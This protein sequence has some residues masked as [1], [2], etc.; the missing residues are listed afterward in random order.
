MPQGTELTAVDVAANLKDRVDEMLGTI[1]KDRDAHLSN[2][3]YLNGIHTLPKIPTFATDEII[4]LRRRAGRAKPDPAGYDVT[5]TRL[6]EPSIQS[7]RFAGSS[8]FP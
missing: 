7:V 1:A 4:E 6:V 2:Q 3:A 8:A 5:A